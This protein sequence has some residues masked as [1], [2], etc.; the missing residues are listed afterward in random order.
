M[1][2][3]SREGNSATSRL[4]HRRGCWRRHT[5]EPRRAWRRLPRKELNGARH[6]AQAKA[7]V[8]AG[9]AGDSV[10]WPPFVKVKE[11]V[12]IN[13][14]RIIQVR[15]EPYN[16]KWS[17]K[18]HHGPSDQYVRSEFENKKEANAEACAFRERANR[19]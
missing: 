7:A 10:R 17:V 13:A 11:G 6:A 16:G 4:S 19:R 8:E 18:Y 15:V 3:S 9:I 12:Y 1:G 2:Q 5:G 14:D